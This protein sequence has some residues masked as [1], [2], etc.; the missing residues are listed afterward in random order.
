MSA[1]RS[2][3]KTEPG[4]HGIEP[5]PGHGP[6]L[7]GALIGCGN[8]ALHAHLPLWLQSDRFRIDAVVEPLKAQA[9]LAKR[10][11]PDA[12]I[13]PEVDPFFAETDIDFVDIC[14]PPCFHADLMLK[15]CRSGLHVMCEKPLI[16]SLETL[17]QVQKT[18]A[19]QERAIF[20]VNNW[21]YAPLWLQIFEWLDQ[22][23]IGAVSDVSLNVLRTS[24]SGGGLSDWRRCP[25]T[26][27]GGILLDHGWHQLYLILSI[28]K[29]SPRSISAAMKPGLAE[30]ADLEETVD[31]ALRFSRAEARLHLT[32]RAPC[33]ENSGTIE[34]DRGKISIHDDHLIMTTDDGPA[35]RHDFPE[36]LS[37]GSHHLEW[38]NPVI[39]EFHRE[40]VDPAV[41][42]T[43]FREA[44]WCAVLTAHAYRSHRQGSRHLTIEAPD[45]Y[46]IVA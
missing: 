31:L 39:S 35:V 27:G 12:R 38:M 20:V 14:T 2:P 3:T 9:A 25:E 19:E 33:R 18:A 41:R 11:L 22:D 21:K 1:N 40:I 26:A 24:A 37:G 45:L 23:R 6:P 44:V 42:G 15:A 28:M 43:N 8:A 46:P 5:S 13:Y 34:G 17:R 30:D 29:E 10:L 32:W 4:K 16:C 7:R 36:S